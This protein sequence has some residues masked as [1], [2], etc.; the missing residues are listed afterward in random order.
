M[1]AKPR[2]KA[3]TRKGGNCKAA[4]LKGQDVCLAHADAKTRA[5]TGFV[6]DNG[7]GGRKPRPTE[8]EMYEKVWL[9]NRPKIEQAL[10]EGITATRHVVVGNGPSA[11]VEEVPDIPT[12]LKAVE[13]FTDRLVGKPSQAVELTGD[14]GGPVEFVGLPASADWHKEV[15][16]ILANTGALDASTDQDE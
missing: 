1:D 6:P 10:T 9:A 13:I 14:E 3:T 16:A 7:K 8:I 4:P 12:R 2:C 15:A 5:R 11:R